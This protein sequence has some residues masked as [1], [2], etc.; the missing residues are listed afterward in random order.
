MIDKENRLIEDIWYYVKLRE[1]KSKLN[2]QS[3]KKDLSK[4]LAENENKIKVKETELKE[5]E[6][7]KKDEW[8]PCPEFGITEKSIVTEVINEYVNDETMVIHIS[9]LTYKVDNLYIEI[10]LPMESPKKET[11]FPVKPKTFDNDIEWVFNK[12]E[13][14]NL[15]KCKINCKIFVKKVFS[16]KLLFEFSIKLKPFQN[17]L[18]HMVIRIKELR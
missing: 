5:I 6:K 4:S 15:Y 9:D 17:T 13:F 14:K 11:I 16:S 3:I 1:E 7:I 2:S 8:V 18:L 10:E 12:Q